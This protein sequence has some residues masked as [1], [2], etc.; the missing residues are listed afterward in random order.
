MPKIRDA[1]DAQL[2]R[3]TGL[4][5]QLPKHK[6]RRPKSEPVDRDL[7]KAI[8]DLN[9]SDSF[10]SSGLS[11]RYDKD[12]DIVIMTVEKLGTR[13]MLRHLSTDE[14]HRLAR[15]LHAGQAR[16]MDLKL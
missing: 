4:D 3:G 7:R 10:K 9:T 11:L 1:G 12:L 15:S 2:Y 6:K 16:I 5:G 8:A 13:E 14:V